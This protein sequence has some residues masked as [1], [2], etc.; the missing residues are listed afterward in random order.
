MKLLLETPLFYRVKKGQ[1]IEEIATAFGCPPI[2]LARENELTSP[3]LGGEILRV[4]AGGNLYCV[5]GGESK[6]LLCGSTKN[7][8]TR[9][10]TRC[11]YPTQ[12]VFL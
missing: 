1:R 12:R 10:K 9:N 6:S 8:E 4:P 3:L 5:Q 11:L 7:F 2:L